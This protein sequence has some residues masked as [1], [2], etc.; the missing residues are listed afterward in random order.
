M[1]FYNLKPHRNRNN[2]FLNKLYGKKQWHFRSIV[3]RN[4]PNNTPLLFHYSSFFLGQMLLYALL[5][6]FTG[7][8]QIQ[9]HVCSF[10]YYMH[11]GKVKL[12]IRRNVT[13]REYM[14]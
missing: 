4:T 9:V 12:V 2:C 13:R 1:P 14:L 5:L 6:S 7:Q 11:V 3:R 10:Y 8:I